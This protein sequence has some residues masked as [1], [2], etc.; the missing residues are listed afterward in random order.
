M[1]NLHQ[2]RGQ[3]GQTQPEPEPGGITLFQGQD[4]HRDF[5]LHR[6]QGWAGQ[7]QPR[8]KAI[9]I[10]LFQRQGQLWGR[11]WGKHAFG[12]GLDLVRLA[13]NSFFVL[14]FC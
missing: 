8:P 14:L 12:G 11:E 6:N 4:L 10:T 13:I 2:D 9:W 5:D 3:D 1:V 7:T